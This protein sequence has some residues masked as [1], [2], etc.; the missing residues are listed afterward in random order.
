MAR[1]LASQGF[2]VTAWDCCT[3]KAQALTDAGVACA[4]SAVEAIKGG[5]IIIFML[6]DS[7]AIDEVLKDKEVRSLPE[8]F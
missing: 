8:G 6:P 5:E 7:E 3:D 2:Q 4:A 1:R